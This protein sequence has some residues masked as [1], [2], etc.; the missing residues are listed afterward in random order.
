V[1]LWKDW[2]YENNRE[3]ESPIKCYLIWCVFFLA[4]IQEYKTKTKHM[5]DNNDKKWVRM[6]NLQTQYQNDIV[7]EENS[8]LRL[9]IGAV[10]FSILIKKK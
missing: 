9:K 6:E 8:Y 5:R 7:A 4:H 1:H 3:Q 2:L 10:N